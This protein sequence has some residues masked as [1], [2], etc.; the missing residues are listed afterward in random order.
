MAQIVLGVSIA[1][2]VWAGNLGDVIKPQGTYNDNFIQAKYIPNRQAIVTEKELI[3]R[4]IVESY[5]R[6]YGVDSGMLVATVR[7]ESGFSPTAHNKRDPNGGSF[8]IA[9]FQWATFYKWAPLLFS[10]PNIH[11]SYQQLETMAYMWS[12]GQAGQWSCW[13]LVRGKAVPWQ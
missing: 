10:E 4:P 7:C 1:L 3:W 11:D 12:K 13:Y 9:Q 8:G 6:K 5:A 2:T